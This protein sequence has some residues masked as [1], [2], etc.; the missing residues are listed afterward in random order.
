ML[1]KDWMTTHV[2]TVTPDD[3]IS[4]AAAI[5]RE[6]NV[7]HLPV[8][9]NDLLVGMLS[10]RDIKAYLPSKGTS[11]DIYEIN[12]LLAKTRV[13][14]AMT[15]PVVS[16]PAETPI[17]DAAMIMHD[18]D[19]G[20]LPVTEP[21]PGGQRVTGIISDNDLFRVMVDI[22]GVRGGGHRLALVL[23]DRPGSIKEAGDLVRARGFRLQSIMSTNEKA[24]PGTRYV[25]LRTRGEGDWDGLLADMGNSPFHLVHAL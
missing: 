12:Y 14:Q 9:E 17:E 20:C 15:R 16:I 10:D 8:V 5:M 25:V 6:R 22:T 24:A 1:V 4:S 2:Y 7:K 3:S 19:F 21:A 18:R 13:S 23:P 11:L